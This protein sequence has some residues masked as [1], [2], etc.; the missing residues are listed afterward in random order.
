MIVRV[1]VVLRR[2]VSG[3]TKWCFDNLSGSHHQTHHLTLTMTSAQVVTSANV[4]TNSPSQNY[5]HP[6]DHTLRFVIWLMGSK[7]LCPCDDKIDRKWFLAISAF[8]CR[9]GWPKAFLKLSETFHLRVVAQF[10]SQPACCSLRQEI[11]LYI[12]SLQQ[13]V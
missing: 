6:N 11:L 5:T 2:T 4:T 9:S 7:N 3:D 8:S 1:S 12:T 10:W 13:G